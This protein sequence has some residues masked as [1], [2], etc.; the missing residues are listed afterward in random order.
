MVL[1]RFDQ[2]NRV[3]PIT[4][5]D[6]VI[7]EAIPDLVIWIRSGKKKVAFVVDLKAETGIK[8]E[9]QVQVERYIK[10]LKK[11]M[12]HK[13]QEVYSKGLV[14]NLV[15]E[16]TSKKLTEGFE[17]IDGVQVLEVRV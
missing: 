4:Y 2:L 10:E 5:T 13:D 8:E 15:K 7:G 14:I 17:E 16:K 12:H 6:H 3:L 11:Q 1:D 9:F